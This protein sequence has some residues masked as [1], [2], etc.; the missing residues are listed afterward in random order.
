M[1][2]L[3]SQIAAASGQRDEL[4]AILAGMDAMPGCLSY[5]VANDLADPDTL[6]VTEVWETSQDHADS[7]ALPRVQAAI[8]LGRPLID[9]FGS[10]TETEPIGGI[11][12][13]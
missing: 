2:G 1:Y 4:A 10:R 9:G 13:S 8:A 6:W 7:L 5:V 11:G 12:L 3:I